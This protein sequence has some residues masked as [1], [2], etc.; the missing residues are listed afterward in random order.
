MRN[1]FSKLW[2]DDAGQGGLEYLLVAT[3]VSLGIIAGLGA[4]RTAL[5]LEF[6]ELANAIRTLDQSFRVCGATYCCNGV[7]AMNTTDTISTTGSLT[8]TAG[9][10]IDVNCP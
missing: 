2:N 7:N 4:V 9:S 3:I 8:T 6:F 1:L 10:N 5:N